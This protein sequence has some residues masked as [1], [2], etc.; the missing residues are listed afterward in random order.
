MATLEEPESYVDPSAEAQPVLLLPSAYFF[1]E[2]IAIPE[3]VTRRELDD[4]AELTLESASPFSLEALYWGYIIASDDSQL[5]IFATLKDR[6]RREGFENLET[7]VWVLPDFAVFSERSESAEALSLVCNFAM[8]P[9]E[10]TFEPGRNLPASHP[11]AWFHSDTEPLKQTD[12]T[13]SVASVRL[14]EKNQPSF[15]LYCKDADGA[16]VSLPAYTL[17]QETLWRADIRPTA[18]KTSERSRR[19]TSNIILQTLGYAAIFAFVL[20]ILEGILFGGKMWLQAKTSRV[21][22]QAPVVRVIEDKQSLLDKLD[23]V[24]QNELRPIEILEAANA[25]RQQLG[26]TGLVYDKVAIEGD[27]RLII[28]GE[29]NTINELNAYT[30]ALRDSG[31]FDLI[32]NSRPSMRSGKTTFTVTLAYEATGLRPVDELEDDSTTEV[33]EVVANPSEQTRS[34]ANT[35]AT[36]RGLRGSLPPQ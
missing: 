15:L 30:D 35:A 17:S 18:F 8:V 1:T 27:N 2:F 12:G 19:R 24:A 13:A 26:T 10:L 14:N 33:K 36:P 21:A 6:L 4:F 31:A 7:Y 9:T 23:Q 5:L 25:I 32:G 11:V 20:V 16:P 29:A 3:G 34:I 28:N 22:E